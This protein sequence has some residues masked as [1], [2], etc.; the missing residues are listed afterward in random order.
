MSS[1]RSRSAWLIVAAGL[2]LSMALVL[3]LAAAQLS[4]TL[5]WWLTLAAPPILYGFLVRL[6]VRRVSP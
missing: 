4:V 1:I 2:A 5:P 3:A 6:S